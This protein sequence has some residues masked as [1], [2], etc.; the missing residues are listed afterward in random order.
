MA[1]PS[2]KDNIDQLLRSMNVV[3]RALLVLLGEVAWGYQREGKHE[4]A[5]AIQ[6]LL[7]E[8]TLV[9]VKPTN[10]LVQQWGDDN[11]TEDDVVD[12]MREVVGPEA[13]EMAIEAYRK[14]QKERS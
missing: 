9:A 12:V 6:N 14:E 7:M 13:T 11:I 3:S 8:L 10:E 4:E 1:R 5:L 2:Q